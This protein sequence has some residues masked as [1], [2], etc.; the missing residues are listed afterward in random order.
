MASVV[1]TVFT[2]ITVAITALQS[3]GAPVA[4][5]TERSQA[6]VVESAFPGIVSLLPAESEIEVQCNMNDFIGALQS[7]QK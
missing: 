2:G 4:C 3:A 1:G 6:V 7:R 5:M